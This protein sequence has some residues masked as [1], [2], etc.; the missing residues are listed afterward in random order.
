MVAKRNPLKL[1][2]LQLRT[3]ALAQVL[4]R[5]PGLARQDADS[6]EATLLHIPKPHGNHMHVGAVVVSMRDASGLDNPAVWLALERK[7]LAR[8]GDGLTRVLTAAGLAYDTGFSDAL[9]SPSDH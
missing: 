1:N 7:G 6:G 3:L 9:T 4:A 2:K 5:E 8:P